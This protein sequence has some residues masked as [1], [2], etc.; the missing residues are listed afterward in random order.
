VKWISKMRFLFSSLAGIFHLLRD[1][2]YSMCGFRHFPATGLPL[3][4]FLDC[5]VCF[6]AVTV[7]GKNESGAFFPDFLRGGCNSNCGKMEDLCHH[8]EKY[9]AF[10]QRGK[11]K[12]RLM[13]PARRPVIPQGEAIHLG[14]LDCFTLRVRNDGH[15]NLNC[16][17]GSGSCFYLFRPGIERLCPGTVNRVR[18]LFCAC[19]FNDCFSG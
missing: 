12:W 6:E 2:F 8:Q 14:T 18:G 7:T 10:R 9:A 15:D 13:R 3:L 4:L 1:F 16:L 11:G 17:C 5:F 19:G